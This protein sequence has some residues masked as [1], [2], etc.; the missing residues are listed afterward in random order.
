MEAEADREA[1]SSGRSAP[2]HQQQDAM[3]LDSD[4]DD[5]TG[6]VS[7]PVTAKEVGES[8]ESQGEYAHIHTPTTPGT[9]L[10]T[11]LA[12]LG[13][14]TTLLPLLPAE[15]LPNHLAALA[16]HLSTTLPNL[17]ALL[18]ERIP[19]IRLT[20]ALLRCAESEAHFRCSPDASTLAAWSATILDPSIWPEDTV[21]TLSAKSDLHISISQAAVDPEVIPSP[22]P[23]VAWKHLSHASLCLGAA[24]KLDP[25]NP[26][27]YL[28]R[29]DVEVMR[30]R[31]QGVEAVEK[32]RGVLRKNAGVY[33]RGAGKVAGEMGEIGKEVEVKGRMVEAE[34]RGDGEVRWTGLGAR[35]V[36]RVV[37]EAV[38]EGVF[39]EE[40]RG[41]VPGVGVETGAVE[42]VAMEG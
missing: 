32:A 33:Y 20:T 12:L 8:G 15:E 6:G 4:D 2:S 23:L 37:Q 31:I 41:R 40:W 35:L 22:H 26:N 7:L 5:E 14:H 13:S 25:T 21:E 16:P 24:S 27:L 17:Q 10:D 28:A 1:A 30:S 18:P 11:L 36:S 38:E 39:G 9:L 3:V 29:G 19:E 34:E 42:D